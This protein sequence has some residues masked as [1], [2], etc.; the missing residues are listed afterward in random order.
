MLNVFVPGISLSG[1]KLFF[2]LPLLFLGYPL[3]V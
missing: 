1:E 3:T 2:S